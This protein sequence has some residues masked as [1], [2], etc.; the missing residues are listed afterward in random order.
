VKAGRHRLISTGPASH[1]APYG[2]WSKVVYIGTRV[3]RSW[4]KVVHYIGTRVPRSWSKVVHYIGTRVPRSWSKVV[5]YIG[6]RVPRPWS[7]VVHYIGTRVPRPLS[8]VVHYIWTREPYGTHSASTILWYVIDK[9]TLTVIMVTI[10]PVT[11]LGLSPS[12]HAG[13]TV[14]YRQERTEVLSVLK[15]GEMRGFLS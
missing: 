2:P 7:K 11:P 5:H 3:P 13:Q 6:T 12:H 10:A 1:V 9:E 14:N 15:G 4:S 8:N